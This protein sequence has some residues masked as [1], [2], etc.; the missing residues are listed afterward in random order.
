MKH[1]YKGVSLFLVASMLFS[2]VA[3]AVD[4]EANGTSE[5]SLDEYIEQLGIDVTDAVNVQWETVEFGSD[6]TD[7]ISGYSVDGSEQDVPAVVV[8]S[9]NEDGSFTT[10]SYVELAVRDDGTLTSAITRTTSGTYY[11]AF[12]NSG[13]V[14]RF[15]ATYDEENM[16]TYGYSGYAYAPR[17]SKY[18]IS[19]SGAYGYPTGVSFYMLIHGQY[20]VSSSNPTS[21][22]DDWPEYERTNYIGTPTLGQQYSYYDYTSYSKDYSGRLVHITNGGE[23][24]YFLKCEFTYNGVEHYVKGVIYNGS[25]ENF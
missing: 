12:A 6:D 8:V 17:Y 14:I 19:S 3:F 4:E 20:S 21:R 11:N 23:G 18:K 1:L 22:K 2:T 10:S 7:A 5:I 13:F 24:S 9:E 15:D 25:D 16:N